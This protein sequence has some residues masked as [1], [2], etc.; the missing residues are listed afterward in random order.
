MKNNSDNMTIILESFKTI[1]LNKDLFIN[2]N[3]D[4]ILKKYNIKIN[5]IEENKN[6]IENKFIVLY[7]QNNFIIKDVLIEI[8]KVFVIV[9]IILFTHDSIVLFCTFF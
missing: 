2:Q 1:I 6:S 7:F 9:V 4:K 3:F 5:A 8:L